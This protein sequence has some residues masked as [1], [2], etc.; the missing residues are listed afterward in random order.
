M[1]SHKKTQ[2]KTQKKTVKRGA[3]I[4][5]TDIKTYDNLRYSNSRSSFVLPKLVCTVKGCNGRLFKNHVLKLGTTTKSFLLNTDIFDN[6]YN[7]F[8]CVNCG[9]V[10]FYSRNLTYVSTKESSKQSS[11]KSTKRSK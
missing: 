6:S 1:P 11:K 3:G 5:S 9:C 2:K 4:F 10:Q 8:T 7:A